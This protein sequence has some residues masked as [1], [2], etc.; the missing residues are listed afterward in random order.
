[1]LSSREIL[2][3]FVNKDVRKLLKRK[4]SDANETG[5]S[6]LSFSFLFLNA[7]QIMSLNLNLLTYFNF[8]DLHFGFC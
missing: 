2:N 8:I 4:G 3:F 6:L 1:M 7:N 5:M